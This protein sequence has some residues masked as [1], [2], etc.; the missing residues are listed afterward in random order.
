LVLAMGPSGHAD[1]FNI[2]KGQLPEPGH[3]QGTMR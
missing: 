1:L 3:Q 2:I